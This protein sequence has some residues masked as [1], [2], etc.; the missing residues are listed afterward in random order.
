MLKF[1]KK[2]RIFIINDAMEDS[3]EFIDIIK[4]EIHDPKCHANLMNNAINEHTW[5]NDPVPQIENPYL[6]R[7]AMTR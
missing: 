2:L 1:T 6:R 5:L 3:L 7:V 4:E